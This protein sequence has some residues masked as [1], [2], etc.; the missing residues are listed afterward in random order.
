MS[1]TFA[2]SMTVAAD[3]PPDWT[4]VAVFFAVAC[5]WSWAAARWGVLSVP[6]SGTTLRID[7]SILVG[8]GPAAGAFAA[9]AFR[10]RRFA[11]IAFF[12][13]N[14]PLAWAALLAPVVTVTVAGVARP[15]LGAHLDGFTLALTVLIYCIGEEL[16]WR[17][18]LQHELAALPRWTG[19]VITA[20]LWYAWHWAFLD[21]L[22][23]DPKF[24]AIFALM[25]LAAS[26]GL[27]A[28]VRSTGG[29]AIAAAWHAASKLLFQ[30]PQIIVMLAVI[31]LATWRGGRTALDRRA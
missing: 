28:A 19:A 21:E 11:P 23:A 2:R 26:F 25:I 1:D 18:W 8:W 7:D 17:G 13:A 24:A 9:A 4:A 6:W 3:R 30:P 16:G 27:A 15:Q 22:R 10:R 29:V 12:G 5:L 14:R 31:A 20:V